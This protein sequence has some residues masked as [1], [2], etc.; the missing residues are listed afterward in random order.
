MGVHTRTNISQQWVTNIES[1][2]CINRCYYGIKGD[3]TVI[4]LG[5]A[6][7]HDEEM[8]ENALRNHQE[9]FIAILRSDVPLKNVA[10]LFQ[11]RTHPPGPL[12]VPLSA[13]GSVRP[14]IR[15]MPPLP[16]PLPMPLRKTSMVVPNVIVPPSVTVAT[17][18]IQYLD[19]PYDVPHLFECQ[20]AR[21]GGVFVRTNIALHYFA[22]SNHCYVTFTAT[23]M[24]KTNLDWVEYSGGSYCPGQ[25]TNLPAQS[26][27][28]NI[29]IST[30][31]MAFYSL[32]SN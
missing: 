26:N 4:D 11:E 22:Q 12:A 9:N 27:V 5:H 28:V 2:P 13:Q 1:R 8:M 6:Y 14:G 25:G 21:M 24:S 23:N 19:L 16:P 7:D 15:P 29:P 3:G 10:A 18:Q 30:N 31:G 17:R 32:R 20:G